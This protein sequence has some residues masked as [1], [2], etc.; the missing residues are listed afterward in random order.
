MQFELLND[1]PLFCFPVLSKVSII[2]PNCFQ[3]RLFLKS[4]FI[5]PVSFGIAHYFITNFIRRNRGGNLV[6]GV[7]ESLGVQIYVVKQR[8]AN[9]W[10]GVKQLFLS[11]HLVFLC[12][13]Y[14]TNITWHKSFQNFD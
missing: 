4:V 12:D 10:S 3:L 8:Y 5:D 13:N 2:L 14:K 1:I 9:P 11:L 7:A 6:S